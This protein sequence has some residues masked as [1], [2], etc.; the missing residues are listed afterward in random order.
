MCFLQV[1][2][3]N[4]PCTCLSPLF[5]IVSRFLPSYIIF[6]LKTMIFRVLC[7][8]HFLLFICSINSDPFLTLILQWTRISAHLSPPSKGAEIHLPSKKNDII[9]LLHSQSDASTWST[10]FMEAL[11]AQDRQTEMGNHRETAVQND[12]CV[13]FYLNNLT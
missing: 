8:S 7:S 12:K 9:F 10:A 11:C 1:N 3:G 4:H 5:L 6:A 13:L 2:L